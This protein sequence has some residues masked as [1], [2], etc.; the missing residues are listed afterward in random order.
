MKF[1]RICCLSLMVLHFAQAN[2][3][4]VIQFTAKLIF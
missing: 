1:L 2:T 4:R 3:P